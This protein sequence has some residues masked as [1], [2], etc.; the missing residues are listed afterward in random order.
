MIPT[1][2]SPWTPRLLWLWVPQMIGAAAWWYVVS[3]VLAG[4][5]S[6]LGSSPVLV[7]TVMA[8]GVI[9]LG[10]WLGTILFGAVLLPWKSWRWLSVGLST[11]PIWFFAP[12]SLWTAAV[13]AIVA[14]GLAIGVEQAYEHA[15]N[16]LLVRT[17]QVIGASLGLPLLA[18]LIGTSL[19]YFQHLQTSTTSPDALANNVVAQSATSVERLL[20]RVKSDY[21]IGMTVDELLGLFIPKSDELLKNIDTSGGTLSQQQQTEVK[22]QLAD[23]GVPIDQVQLDFTQTEDQLR[24]AIDGQ[25]NQFRG[26]IIAN[27]R[28]ELSRTLRLDMKGDETVQDVLQSYFGRQFNTYIRA[29]LSWLPPLLALALFFTLQLISIIFQWGI[30]LVGWI[31]YRLLK[32]TRVLGVV[33]ETVPAERLS[34]NK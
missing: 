33:H 22:Q 14:V 7:V 2:A 5:I 16:S 21:R 3:R 17:R 4:Q 34:W 6:I 27:L 15:H 13:W 9:G 31:W 23:R 32:L 12:A 29:Y 28:D 11:L 25:I 19:L 18:V 30:L 8:L 20:P 26:Q 24:L 1:A 10:W